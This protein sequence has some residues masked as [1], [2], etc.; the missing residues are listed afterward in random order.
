VPV[1]S[2]ASDS[3]RR[4]APVPTLCGLLRQQGSNVW[5]Q[6]AT[7][8]QWRPCRLP[9]ASTQLTNCCLRQRRRISRSHINRSA[10]CADET[11]RHQTVGHEV[12]HQAQRACYAP[13]STPS[14][15]GRGSTY[16]PGGPTGNGWRDAHGVGSESA[17]HSTGRQ[18]RSSGLDDENQTAVCRQRATQCYSVPSLAPR[19]RH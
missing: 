13:V 7:R 3:A 9:R 4:P 11:G 16:P 5:G 2:Q 6:L 8:H 1:R 18:P 17:R 14:T 15:F 10:A 12:L 19:P